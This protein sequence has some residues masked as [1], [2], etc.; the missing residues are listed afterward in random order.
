MKVN[1]NSEF[2]PV[3]LEVIFETQKELDVFYTLFDFTPICNFIEEEAEINFDEVIRRVLRAN[4]SINLHDE[5][6]T[7]IAKKYGSKL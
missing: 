7:Y 1:I 4:H 6:S 3:K 5:L 2:Q